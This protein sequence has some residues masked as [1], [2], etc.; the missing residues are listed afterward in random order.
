MITVR[1]FSAAATVEVDRNLQPHTKES[2]GRDGWDGE[3][4]LESYSSFF[5]PSP[6]TVP[7]SQ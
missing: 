2:A 1:T 4:Y 3:H 7:V 6:P 5:L